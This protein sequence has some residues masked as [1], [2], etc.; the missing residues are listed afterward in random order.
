MGS[1]FG[2]CGFALWLVRVRV[3][4]V[5]HDELVSIY[6]YVI[7]RKC[8]FLITYHNS[9]LGV[10]KII[11]LTRWEGGQKYFRITRGEVSIGSSDF[12]NFLV[13]N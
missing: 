6:Y 8:N 5:F 11:R 7:A 12:I 9:S 13:I 1:V 4:L 2:R 3:K 10:V